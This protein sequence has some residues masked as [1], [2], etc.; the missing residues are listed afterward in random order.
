MS[1]IFYVNRHYWRK[2]WAS[3]WEN[4]WRLFNKTY[5]ENCLIEQVFVKDSDK[6]IKQLL[7]ENTNIKAF[8]RFSYGNWESGF[9][10]TRATTHFRWRKNSSRKAEH[11][12]SPWMHLGHVFN[13]IGIESF[14]QRRFTVKAQNPS[15]YFYRARPC[16][17]KI[18][19]QYWSLTNFSSYAIT[20]S[21]WR[22]NRGH[23][24]GVRFGA[25]TIWSW[26]KTQ[27]MN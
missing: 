11:T 13:V 6:T 15:V 17:I 19:P 1:L 22:F 18:N 26:G 5:K 8:N 25:S 14:I 2:A 10:R 20:T 12:M 24:L 7:P 21:K 4:Y 27:P 23:C 3:N 16:S 9:W